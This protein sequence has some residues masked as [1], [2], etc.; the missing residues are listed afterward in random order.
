MD[1][2]AASGEESVITDAGSPSR[3]ARSGHWA[4]MNPA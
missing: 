1:E 3:A 4:A 2:I